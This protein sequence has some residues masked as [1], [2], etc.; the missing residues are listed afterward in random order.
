[1]P[2]F[3]NSVIADHSRLSG[4]ARCTSNIPLSTSSIMSQTQVETA[5]TEPES[6]FGKV[7]QYVQVAETTAER[8]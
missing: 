1:M 8:Q 4:A 7:P 2:V 5:Q 6:S 3:G